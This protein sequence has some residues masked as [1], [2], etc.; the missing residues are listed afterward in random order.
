MQSFPAPPWRRQKRSWTCV[1]VVESATAA[2]EASTTLTSVAGR[3]HGYTPDAPSLARRICSGGAVGG[4]EGS[5]GLFPPLRSP[6][7]S[8]FE[9]S[10]VETRP[11]PRA[12]RRAIPYDSRGRKDSA[13]PPQCRPRDVTFRPL[14]VP[15]R[16]GRVAR[17][18]LGP[19]CSLR[20]GT[21]SDDRSIGWQATPTGAVNPIASGPGRRQERSV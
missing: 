14:D 5:I 2:R 21:G 4:R 7:L 11:A 1:P 13:D 17:A 9:S 20:R 8:R 16:G 18:S 10:P 15:R 6:H 12:A 3:C 19:G